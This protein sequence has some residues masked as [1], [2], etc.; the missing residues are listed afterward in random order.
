MVLSLTSGTV[1]VPTA[2]H[3]AGRCAGGGAEHTGRRADH[4]NSWGGPP[5]V[6]GVVDDGARGRNPTTSRLGYG[7]AGFL[8]RFL[9]GSHVQPDSPGSHLRLFPPVAVVGPLGE[10]YIAVA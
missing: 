6:A 1:Q 3:D 9:H 8:D 7:D 4:V 5:V 2:T 10:Q